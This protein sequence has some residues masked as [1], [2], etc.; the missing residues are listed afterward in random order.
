MTTIAPLIPQTSL[1]AMGFTGVLCIAVPIV[2][3]IVFKNRFQGKAAILLWRDYFCY[4]CPRP[5]KLCSRIFS[6]RNNGS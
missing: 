1:L 2:L 3:L 6:F 5:G 4:F